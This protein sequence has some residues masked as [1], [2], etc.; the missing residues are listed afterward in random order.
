MLKKFVIERDIKG[1]GSF[2]QSE[3]GGASRTSNEALAKLKGMQGE[4]S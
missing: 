1:V 3:L 2:P 4:H